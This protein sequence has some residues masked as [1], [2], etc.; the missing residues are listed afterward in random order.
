MPQMQDLLLGLLGDSPSLSLRLYEERV[1]TLA[2]QSALPPTAFKLM[3]IS[4]LSAVRELP[5]KITY[6]RSML[7][8]HLA[9]FARA[10]HEVMSQ[11][12]VE[13]FVAEWELV[14]LLVGG[15]LSLVEF[16]LS[17]YDLNQTSLANTPETE[18]I[19]SGSKQSSTPSFQWM[20]DEYRSWPKDVRDRYISDLDE[21]F[22]SRQAE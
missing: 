20:I 4:A 3:A 11:R 15:E 2:Q 8:S 5:D 16:D 9:P 7:A 6:E 12:E 17:L 14:E 21:E 13:H 18:E 22:R 10:P 19:T 1:R